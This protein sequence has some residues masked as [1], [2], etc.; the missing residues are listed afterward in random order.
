M[1]FLGNLFGGGSR[2]TGVHT[3]TSDPPAYAKPF[4]ESSMQRAEDLYQVPKEYYPGQTYVDFSP[5]TLAAL[6]MGEARAAGGS[7]LLRGAQ[8]FTQT[9]MTGGFTNPAAAM[10]QSTAQGDFL[11]GNNPYLS[12]ALQPAIDRVQGAYSGSGRLGSG[13]NISAMTGALAPVY[14]RNYAQERQNQIAAQQAIGNLAQ[15]DFANRFAAARAAP[16]LAAADYADI[17]RLSNFGALRER[18][19]AEALKDDIARFNFMQNEPE[20]RLQN[21]L[22]SIRGGTFGGSRSQ[23]I[24]QD[25]VGQGIGNLANLGQAAYLFNKAGLF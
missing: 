20:E 5:T 23:P 2:Q 13:A 1:S 22:A 8:D 25:R 15:T 6:D 18:K 17:D 3:I 11:S 14:A 12:A 16:T 21:F 9:A 7:P 10:L 24:Y 19:T 4:F